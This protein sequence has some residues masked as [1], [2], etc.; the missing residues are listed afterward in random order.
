MEDHINPT[1]D[2]RGPVVARRAGFWQLS[3]HRL[4]F[5]RLPMLMG[6]VNITPDSFSDGGQ[7]FD[8]GRA[9]DHALRLAGE[10]ADI[11]D[12]GGESTRPYSTPVAEAEELRR[13]VP[14][15]RKLAEQTTVPISVDT[16][17]APVAR[18]ALAA[19]AQIVNDVTAGS[20]DKRMLEAIA[21]T[22]AGFCM[23]HMRGTPQTMQDDP[24]YDDVVEEVYGYLATRR[25]AAIAADIDPKAIALDPGIGFGKRTQHNS[26]LLSK[27][28]RFHALGCAV[29]VGHSRKGFI[30]KIQGD[31]RQERLSGTLGVA[32]GLARQGV[33][34]I[35]VH[36]VRAV[37]SALLLFASAGGLE[38]IDWPPGPIA[39]E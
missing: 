1:N 32:L 8:A 35:R 21:E 4:V 23:M 38:P 30:G 18:E 31:M 7:Y 6:I 3:R 27:A 11:L 19:G 34:V 33:Q 14:V 13:V 26:E 37:R 25:E 12:V 20:A 29:L 24:R 22:K 9:V 15:V 16:S 5:G 10:G 39:S 2:P 36:D 28:W 17:K